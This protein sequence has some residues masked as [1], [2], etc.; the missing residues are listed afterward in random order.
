MEQ[1]A[2]EAI[3]HLIKNLKTGAAVSLLQMII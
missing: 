1:L 3:R 2:I